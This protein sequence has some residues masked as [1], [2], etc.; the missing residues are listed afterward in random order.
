M[1]RCE[2]NETNAGYFDISLELLADM[3]HLPD[4]VRIVRV[5]EYTERPQIN[6]P[7]RIVVAG[8]GL[9]AARDGEPIER[10]APTYR[11]E[12]PSNKVEF[13]SW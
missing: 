8:D 10:V 1:A 6:G 13:V 12:Y 2:F 9:P 7:I 11:T 4:G 5:H 3:L